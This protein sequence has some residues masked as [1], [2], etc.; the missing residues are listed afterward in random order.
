[1]YTCGAGLCQC[2][3]IAAA[4]GRC[5]VRCKK[6]ALL[7]GVRTYYYALFLNLGYCYGI[8]PL[9]QVPET[10]KPAQ[11]MLAQPIVGRGA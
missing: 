1:M 11:S 7:S 5:T 8:F 4:R 3:L 10:S 9:L 6:A 2:K